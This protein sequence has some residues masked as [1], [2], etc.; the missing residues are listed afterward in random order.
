MNL[1]TPQQQQQYERDGLTILR[2]VFSTREC[3]DLI[4]HMQNIVN[5]RVVLPGL[6]KQIAAGA[7]RLLNPHANDPVAMRWL[8]HERLQPAL[9]R[10]AGGPVEGI[11]TMY[12]WKGSEQG[13]HQDAFY[14]PGCFSAWIAL[15]PVSSRNGTIWVQPGS[16][17]GR[18]I[19]VQDRGFTNAQSPESWSGYYD[20]VAAL[21][22]ANGT[23]EVPVEAGTGD[24]VLFDG[25]LIHRGG[26]IGDP[27]AS[28]H[29][30]ANH[31]LPAAFTEWPYHD[32]P[33]YSFD[34]GKR[35]TRIDS[36]VAAWK[37]F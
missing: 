22:R 30:F 12:F 34:G 5:G 9:E 28:R 18:L 36:S 27:T 33:R 8:L 19:T 4:A 15:E 13:H 3:A 10:C 21:A 17:K 11:Q 20:E 16:H 31:Y 6:D 35:F 14:L 24:V 2:G 29:V 23:P 25:R 7:R 1:L 37:T 26:P 32:W